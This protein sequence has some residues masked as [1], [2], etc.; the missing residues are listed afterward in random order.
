LN[1]IGAKEK[2]KAETKPSILIVDD[3]EANVFYMEQV[4]NPL[5]INVIS[6]F[7]GQDAIEKI[8]GRDLALALID[9]HMPEMDGIE[10]AKIILSDDTRDIVP[11]LFVTAFDYD[12]IQLDKCYASG[13]IDFILKPFRVN[14]LLSKVRILLELNRQKCKVIE[15]EKMYRTLLNAS[16]EGIIIMD[17]DGTIREISNVITEVF[18]IQDKNAFIGQ[19]IL[20]LF[21]SDERERLQG[22]ITKTLDEGLAQNVEF[23]LTKADQKHFA[24]EISITLIRDS[25]GK[26]ASLM[27]I[28]RDI[29]YRKKMEQQMVHSERMA[30]IGEMATGIAHEINQPLNTISLGIE[31]LLHEIGKNNAVDH[32]YYQNKARKIFENISRIDY[33][34]DHIRT[35]SRGYDD[36]IHSAFSVNDSIMDSIFMITEQFKHK[37]IEIVLNLDE[38]IVPIIGNTYKFEQVVLNLLLNS[39][40]ALEEKQRSLA[41]EFRKVIEIKNYQKDKMI[42]IEV[43]DNGMGI[44]PEAIDSVMFPFFTTKEVGKGTGLGLSISFGIV[45]ELN[46]NIEISSTYTSG[47]TVRIT[48]PVES[49]VTAKRM[50]FV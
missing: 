25:R 37:G 12:E 40:D 39:K 46:G 43:I 7:S 19:D 26:P 3:L 5:N 8:K 13:I 38:K 42:T 49:K 27:A 45:K 41:T 33:I 24:G 11:I 6:A 44:K 50:A 16:P 35:F 36:Y 30:G 1:L 23:K 29:T 10:L 14:I 32:E 9:I 34:I 17:P 28:I 47:A 18:G 4:L 22:L 15:S 48:L 31:N 20:L 21:P 2:M